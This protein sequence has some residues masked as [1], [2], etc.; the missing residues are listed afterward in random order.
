LKSKEKT[1]A[2]VI[3]K[4]KEISKNMTVASKPIKM[5]GKEV[6]LASS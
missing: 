5:D 1:T 4:K 2:F 3:S 6:Y